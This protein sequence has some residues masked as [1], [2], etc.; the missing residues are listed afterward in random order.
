V[1]LEA[2]LKAL[3]SSAS[4]KRNDHASATIVNRPGLGA[5][6]IALPKGGHLAAHRTA[7]PI[8]LRVLEG[9]IQV[10]LGDRTIEMVRGDLTA[11]APNLQHKVTGVEESAFL[12]TMGGGERR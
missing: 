9:I 8:T 2:E 1:N 5:V 3:R 7:R 6:L 10:S 12:L 4:Y 11:L